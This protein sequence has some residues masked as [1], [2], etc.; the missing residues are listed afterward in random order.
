[1]QPSYRP[2]PQQAPQR[3]PHAVASRRGIGTCI[4]TSGPVSALSFQIDRAFVTCSVA[5]LD[6][7]IGPMISGPHPQNSMTTA[8]AQA[9][10]LAHENA[11]ERAKMRSQKPTDKNLPEG[12][13]EYIIGDGVQ[14]YKD[15]RDV[16]RRLD[17]TM[18]RKRLDITDAV[19]RNVKASDGFSANLLHY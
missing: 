19:N 4:A 13:E 7:P 17:A 9:Q 3:S 1:M 14:L 12:I 2:F 15:L 18:M 16:E 11:R 5:D 6:F 8:Q 10:H